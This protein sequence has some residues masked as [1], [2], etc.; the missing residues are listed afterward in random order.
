MEIR[1]LEKSAQSADKLSQQIGHLIGTVGTEAFERSLFAA[2]HGATGC[3][4]LTAFVSAPKFS[5]RPLVT[6]NC[7]PDNLARSVADRY[8]RHYW[9]LDPAN[10]FAESGGLP[11]GGAALL[12]RSDDIGSARYRSDC[13]TKIDL[14]DRFSLIRRSRERLLRINFYSSRGRSFDETAILDILDS[15]DVLM[16]LLDR[17]ENTRPATDPSGNGTFAERLRSWRPAMTPRE[18]QVCDGIARGL[19][20][21]GIAI[22]NGI[23][24]NTVL[25]Y[26][27]RAYARLGISSQ[28]ELLRY[29]MG[30]V[31]AVLP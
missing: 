19:T 23:S 8:I 11:E 25:T 24:I 30:H 12:T 17:H 9:H 6:A 14:G 26:R 5:A 7:G 29:V 3:S 22:E 15:A 13:Y 27:K 21:E 2:A 20:S 28:N 18:I 1:A 4:H 16:A 31:S 10:D